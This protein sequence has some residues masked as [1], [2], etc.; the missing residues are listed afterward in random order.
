ME[1]I[2]TTGSSIWP[3]FLMYVDMPSNVIYKIFFGRPR[4]A[5]KNKKAGSVLDYGMIK[6]N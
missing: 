6:K 5:L 1:G 2:I 4:K 3:T